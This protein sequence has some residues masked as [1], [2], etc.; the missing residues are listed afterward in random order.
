MLLNAR[1]SSRITPTKFIP[2]SLKFAKQFRSLSIAQA[3]V[4]KR[5]GDISDAFTSL[6]GGKPTPLEPRFAHLKRRLIARKEDALFASWTRLLKHL[7]EEVTVVAALGSSIVPEIS[8]NDIKAGTPTQSFSESYKQR[9]VCVIRGVI[10]QE[11]ALGYKISIR[12]YI[13]RNPHTKA[14]PAGDPQVYELYW[15]EAQLRARAHPNLINAQ[16]FLMS[17]WHAGSDVPISLE[18]PV[19]YAD[20]LRIRQPGDASFALGPH[21]DGGSLERWEESGYGL[22]GNGKGVYSSILGGHWENYDPW[23]A[24]VRLGVVSD[25]YAGVGACGILRTAQGWLSMSDV[26]AGEGHLLVNPMLRAATAY[27]L[28]RPFFEAKRSVDQVSAEDYL[29]PENWMLETEATTQFQGAT[30]GH[31][32]ELNAVLHPH[33]ELD[34]SMVH[35]PIVNPGDY[36]AWH[37]DTIHAVDKTH[38]GSSDSSVLY[39]PVCPLTEDNAIFLRRQRGTFLKGEPSPDF[40]GGEGESNHE[41]RPTIEDVPSLMNEDGMRAMGLK[42]WDSAATDLSPGQRFVMDRANKELEFCI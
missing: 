32:Q 27:I 36:V 23:D 15:S 10:S 34:K 26:S 24:A 40:G 18:H 17:Y 37:C 4:Q 11:E 42:E 30:P 22:G 16:K 31:G 20:R 25:L 8:Y 12:E 9:G 33:L 29:Q 6:S 5:A 21:V 41:G 13:R 14:F 7:R 3:Q 19:S 38:N 35:M 39:I 2:S 28:L 1:L